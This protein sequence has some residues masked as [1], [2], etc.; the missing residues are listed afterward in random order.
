MKWKVT[1]TWHI[2]S[3]TK[4]QCILLS[5]P[6]PTTTLTPTPGEGGRMELV[7]I[8][9]WRLLRVAGLFQD[10]ERCSPPPPPLEHHGHHWNCLHLVFWADAAAAEVLLSDGASVWETKERKTVFGKY[11]PPSPGKQEK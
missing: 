2:G 5:L 11:I 3:V 10:K 1:T 7:Y 6:L 8:S 4:C 9:Q